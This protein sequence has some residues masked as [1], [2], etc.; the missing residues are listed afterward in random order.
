MAISNLL[1]ILVTFYNII[2]P[3]DDKLFGEVYTA[4]SSS[5]KAY[6][7]KHKRE[8]TLKRNRGPLLRKPISTKAGK[9]NH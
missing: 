4:K 1:R 7:F 9:A 2:A 3:M 5:Q 8:R 6:G